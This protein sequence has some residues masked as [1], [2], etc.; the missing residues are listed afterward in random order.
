MPSLR[1][2]GPYP[3]AALFDSL[4]CSFVVQGDVQA[5]LVRFTTDVERTA[6]LGQMHES[7]VEFEPAPFEWSWPHARVCVQRR[8]GVERI[9]IDGHAFDALRRGPRRW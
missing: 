5:A 3:T 4:L 1:Y 7:D 9:F 6:V 2:R 8:D